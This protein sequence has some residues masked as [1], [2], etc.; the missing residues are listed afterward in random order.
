MRLDQKATPSSNQE[1][2]QMKICKEELSVEAA[3]KLLNGSVVPRPIAWVTTMSE[4]KV[5]NLAP[6][7]CFT[8]LSAN[9]PLVGFTVGPRRGGLKDT[10]RNL[11]TTP[12]FVVHIADDSMLE[13]LHVSA[14]EFPPE[15]SEVDFLKLPMAA[16]ER[17]RVP[18]LADAPIAMECVLDQTV[19]FG[20]SGSEFVVGAVELFH[21]REGL[22]IDGKIESAALRPLGRLAGPTYC[23]L[24]TIFSKRPNR[25]LQPGTVDL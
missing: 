14:D 15:A 4:D 22:C 10:A 8:F 17:I 13:A 9:P 12:E 5:V 6:F 16:S 11:R 3:Y 20:R 25:T 1:T 24:G 18:R 23:S 7:S 19:R 21:F 2:I